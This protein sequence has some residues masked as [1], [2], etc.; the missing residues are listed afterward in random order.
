MQAT[1][2]ET[3]PPESTAQRC[4]RQRIGTRFLW[5]LGIVLLAGVSG[6]FWFRKSAGDASSPGALEPNILPQVLPGFV[7]KDVAIAGTESVSKAVSEGLGFSDY[8]YREYR[9]GDRWFAVY[10]AHWLPRTRHFAEVGTHVPDNCWVTSGW[11]LEAKE[12]RKSFARRAS[13]MATA[14]TRLWPAEARR[15]TANGE[16]VEVVYWHLLGGRPLDYTRYGTGKTMEYFWDNRQAYLHGTDEQFFLRI[17]TNVPWMEWEREAGF[18]NVLA[19][20]AAGIPLS[21]AGKT[22]ETA[23]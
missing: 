10:L 5:V 11:K 19:R 16:S 22:H 1:N 21:P 23:P 14:D 6:Q 2:N 3:H 7:V 8:R 9:R 17:S 18:K 4:R 15:F 20:L 12:P 13:A